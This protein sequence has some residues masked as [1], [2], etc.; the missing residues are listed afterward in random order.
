MRLRV[1]ARPFTTSPVTRRAF[2][3][4]PKVLWL[5]Q[6]APKIFKATF[7]FLQPRDVVL[8]RLTGRFLTDESHANCTLFFELTSHQWSGYLFEQFDLDSGFSLTPCHRGLWWKPCPPRWQPRPDSER[9]SDR[10]RCWRQSVRRFRAGSLSGA[11]QRDVRAS[12]CLNSV[13]DVPRRDQRITHYNHVVPDDLQPRSALTRPGSAAVVVRQLGFTSFEQLSSALSRVSVAY[14]I[15]RR[16]KIHATSHR[17]S[18]LH[19]RR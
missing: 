11:D 8:H 5:R 19:G 12:S 16:T 10:D 17:S 4:G 1:G 13:V 2:H 9:G 3:V 6:H 18:S 15:S 7:Q 14:D